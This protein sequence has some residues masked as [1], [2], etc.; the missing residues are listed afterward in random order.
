MDLTK[1]PPNT[2]AKARNLCLED[3]GNMGSFTQIFAGIGSLHWGPPI[4]FQKGVLDMLGG[5]DYEKHEVSAE[6]GPVHQAH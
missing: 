3:L 4:L 6:M 5:W 2:M 1:A